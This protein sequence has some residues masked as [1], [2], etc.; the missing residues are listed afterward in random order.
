MKLPWKKIAGSAIAVVSIALGAV[1]AVIANPQWL[2]AREMAYKGFR[3]YSGSPVDPDLLVK[4]DSA[5][6][7][8]G[9]SELYDADWPID[10]CLNDGSAYTRIVALLNPPGFAWG[11]YNKVVLNGTLDLPRNEVVLNGYSWNLI[12]LIAHEGV[13]CLQYH[14]FG[15][16][17]TL[18][19]ANGPEWKTEG[20]PEF[21][22]RG[23][24]T[25]GALREDIA[26]L[27]EAERTENNGWIA[28]PDSSGAPVAYYRNW[29]L[30]EYAMLVKGESYR[31][32]VEEGSS[33]QTVEGEMMRWYE[34]K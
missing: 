26:R 24:R 10:I 19:F 25:P 12:Q 16:L 27:R 29:L 21:I 17:C 7:L 8:L 2:Y 4:L 28:F 30:V 1:I 3:V 9:Q 15:L 32:L 14:R 31:Q 23:H 20:Y 33:E 5:A 11:F 18:P 22:A 6:A 13:H 34:G